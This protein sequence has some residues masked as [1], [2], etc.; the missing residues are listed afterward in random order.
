MSAQGIAFNEVGRRAII[1][2]PLWQGGDYAEG[3]PPAHGCR[4]R[5]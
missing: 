4:W 1:G 2:D 5:G 3:E